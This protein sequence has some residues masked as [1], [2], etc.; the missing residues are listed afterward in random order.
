[1]FRTTIIIAALLVSGLADAAIKRN[2]LD[3]KYPT[4]QAVEKQSITNPL[5]AS[6]T[7]IV[8]TD[9]AGTSGSAATISTFSA[10]PDVP[11]NLVIT[12]GATTADVGTCTVTVTGTDFYGQALTEEFSI[13]ANQSTA[14]TGSK[15]F[16]TVTSVA[17]PA[18]C[19]DSPYTA[20]W[21]IGSGEK[22][23]L[24]YCLEKAGHILFS[25]IDGAKEG[26]APTMA[27]N[28]S[29]VSSNTADFN[30]TMDGAADFELFFFQNFRCHP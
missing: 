27:A 7:N 25:T 3:Q 9:A 5:G 20:A 21:S 6:T 26:T 2:F 11:R 18:A 23:G 19:E 10:Q 22:L 16:K 15:A 29:T 14:T 13:T 4:Q 24:K 17:L 30:G 28:T 1:M 8:N 12:P